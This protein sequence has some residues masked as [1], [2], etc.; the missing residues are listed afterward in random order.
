[1]NLDESEVDGFIA[2]EQAERALSLFLHPIFL[3]V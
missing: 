2:K 3:H 1:M